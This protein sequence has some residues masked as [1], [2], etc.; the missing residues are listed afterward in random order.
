MD[1]TINLASYCADD[2]CIMDR[3]EYFDD[4]AFQIWND[5]EHNEYDCTL[6]YLVWASY[7][8]ADY[9]CEEK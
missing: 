5:Q 2:D 1:N 9:G 8:T 7:Q 4:Y 6:A 3:E